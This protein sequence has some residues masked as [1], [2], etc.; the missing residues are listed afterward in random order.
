M[1]IKV[2]SQQCGTHLRFD[3]RVQTNKVSRAIGDE[4]G[5][6]VAQWFYEELLSSEVID[7]SC[8]PYALDMAVGKLR[9]SG[10]APPRWAPFI[11]MGA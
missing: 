5:P 6:K 7:V 11:H 9:E 10:V 2:W 8:V 3:E 4:D 1:D